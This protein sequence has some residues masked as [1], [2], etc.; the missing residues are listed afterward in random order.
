MSLLQPDFSTKKPI[1]AVC[2][3]TGYQGGSVVRHLLQDGR[4][5]VR[6][7][8]RKPD[9]AHARELAR[10]G[11]VV[12]KADFDDRASLQHAFEDCYGAYGMT[13]YYDAGEKEAQQGIN[14]V[15]AA[16]VAKLKHLVLCT[17]PVLPDTTVGVFKSK[18][19]TYARLKDS[20]VPYTAFAVG[21]YYGNI[22]VYNALSKGVN[23]DWHLNFPFPTDAPIPSTSPKDIGAYVLAAFANPSEWIGKEMLVCNEMVTPRQYAETFSEVTGFN[24]KI[25]ETTMEQFLALENDP[26][27]GDRWDVYK[28]FLDQFEKGNPPMS[29]E[30]AE[31]LCPTKQ[32][33]RDFAKEHTEIPTSQPLMIECFLTQ[34][35]FH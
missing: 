30:L 17:V 5:A 18:A 14:I 9:S 23:G 8:T 10:A 1:I 7:L 11:A 21:F 26:G 4:F 2:G 32:S 25:H 31:R 27:M 13:D 34:E 20:G 15:E 35:L 28:W 33:W 6:A 3:S 16:K 24:V 12:I 19:I 29:T 22:F